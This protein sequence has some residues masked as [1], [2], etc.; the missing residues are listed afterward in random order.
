[1]QMS[2][3]GWR[4]NVSPKITGNRIR[5]IGFIIADKNETP[6]TLEVDWIKAYID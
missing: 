4:P 2:V 3:M 1:M 6:F 5:A